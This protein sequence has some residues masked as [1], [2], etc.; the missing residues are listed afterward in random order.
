[1][2]KELVYEQTGL[3][4][5]TKDFSVQSRRDFH[6]YPQYA[7]RDFWAGADAGLRRLTLEAVRKYENFAY[8]M[9]PAWEYREYYRT[10]DRAGFEALYDIRRQ[11]L[12]T[13]VMAECLEG[14]GRYI[15]DIVNGIWCICEESTWVLPAHN[16]IYE[17]EA[18]N[19]ER[20]LPDPDL[21][22]LDIFASET[23]MLLSTTYYLLKDRLDEEEP[24]V[25]RRLYRE[26]KRRIIDPFLTRYDY[27]WMGYSER[28]DINNWAPWC[29]MNCI[30][31][32]LFCEE[33]DGLRKRAVVRAMDMLETYLAGVSE[34]GGCD[35]GA[36]YWGRS[37][38]MLLEGFAM[39]Y[40]ATN[41]A[42][43]IYGQSKMRNFANYIRKLF[44]AKNYVVN[45]ADGAARCNPAAELLYTAGIRMGD[46]ALADFGAYC[47]V[48]QTD[49]GFFA[50]HSLNRAMM[51]LCRAE[52]MR[53]RQMAAPSF[54]R[55]CILP[56]LGILVSREQQDLERGFF[57]C[58]KAGTNG[59]SHN[60]NDVGNFVVYW[61]GEPV[62]VDVGVEVY[63]RNFFSS[64]RYK[65]W[66][67]QS[68]YHNLPTI[69]GVMQHEGGSFAA[70]DVSFSTGQTDTL[71]M[72]IAG[73]YPAGAA[74]ERYVRR[75][76]LDR[77]K[78]QVRITDTWRLVKTESLEMHFMTPA[79]PQSTEDGLLIPA[80]G[81]NVLL[82]YDTAH[83]AAEVETR[84]LTDAKLT[85]SWG[86]EMN[87][88]VLKY[89]GLE[90]EG[91][92]VFTIREAD[93]RG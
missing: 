80:G 63:R 9:L 48:W 82:V 51:T 5:R 91:T 32:V 29:I 61:N 66:T 46:G 87:R 38:G 28:R 44:I 67:M 88:V 62:L 69:N 70:R 4:V 92:A 76:E 33:E 60:H 85:A 7:G 81:G 58:A 52:E 75:A 55:S 19:G 27:W 49:Q 16:F 77:E 14:E 20:T 74:V 56:D 41:G 39:L 40:E 73:A 50:P 65:I 64:D 12:G 53:R 84:Y 42:I 6:P 71:V 35:E 26:L 10:G 68:Q 21:P 8:P 11:A 31:A 86:N 3:G 13:L 25:C 89:L 57:L 93:Q 36:T 15:R 78:K 23:A 72:D 45:F 17:P 24:L 34:D 18:V 47:F 37:C 90:K 43:D 1:M 2:L 22:T 83:W 79:R 30:T 59:D 54:E